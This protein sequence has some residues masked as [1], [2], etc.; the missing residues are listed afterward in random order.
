MDLGFLKEL[1]RSLSQVTRLTFE[2]RDKESRLFSTATD[3]TEMPTSN[4]VKELSDQIIK[5]SLFHRASSHESV[6]FD[7]GEINCFVII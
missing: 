1:L 4:R 3:R 5:R 6:S 7:F 2:V